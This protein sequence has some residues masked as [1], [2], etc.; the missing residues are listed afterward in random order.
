[1]PEPDATTVV[2][3]RDGTRLATDVYLPR[4][5]GRD[6]NHVALTQAE[7]ELQER[8]R[9]D[10]DRMAKKLEIDPTLIANRSQLAQI[11]RAP[12][13]VAEILLPWQ[14]DLLRHE[15]SLKQA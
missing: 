10:R 6:P 8:I 3:A 11:A 14:A 12:E 9:A 2:V 4:R 5:P 13:K 7:I 15:P 1:M